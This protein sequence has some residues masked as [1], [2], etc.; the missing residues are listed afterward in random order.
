MGLTVALNPPPGLGEGLNAAVRAALGW[1]R[2]PWA[3]AGRELGGKA[4]R[5]ERPA[6]VFA[7][8]ALR[9]PAVLIAILAEA[10]IWKPAC[11]S[12]SVTGISSVWPLPE[13]V[14]AGASLSFPK[15]WRQFV[16]SRD[17]ESF[18]GVVC[19]EL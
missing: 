18:W 6:P 10:Q 19:W 1:R 4:K 14:G 15:L 2:A 12:T 5:E 13:L 7:L 3:R 8:G 9:P 17:S 16:F 11:N